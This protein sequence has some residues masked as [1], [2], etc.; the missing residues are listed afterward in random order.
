M[1][2]SCTFV[3]SLYCIE[4]LNGLVMIS[5]HVF[6]HLGLL[7]ILLVSFPACCSDW[8]EQW[9]YKGKRARPWLGAG[10]ILLD[11]LIFLCIFKAQYQSIGNSLR[12]VKSDLRQ[13]FLCAVFFARVSKK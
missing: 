9:C 6:F 2:V 1:F 13:T 8:H 7:M 5:N 12:T 10:L 3:M 4:Y 11:Y